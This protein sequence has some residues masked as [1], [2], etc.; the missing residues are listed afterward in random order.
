MP[1]RP[2]KVCLQGRSAVGEVCVWLCSDCM[3]AAPASHATPASPIPARCL[4]RLKKVKRCHGSQTAWQTPVECL[5]AAGY[6]VCIVA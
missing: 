4:F 1:P 3:G 5:T 2:Q 6:A